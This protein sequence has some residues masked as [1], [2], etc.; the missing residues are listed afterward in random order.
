VLHFQK[1]RPAIGA[2]MTEGELM[3]SLVHEDASVWTG[4][5]SDLQAHPSWKFQL[6]GKASPEGTVQ[7]NS[8]LAKR[9]ALLV[10]AALKSNK[11][12][13]RIVVVKPECASVEP[14]V[15]NCGASNAT[16]PEDRQVKVV[17]APNP[18]GSP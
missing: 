3:K 5:V 4:L 10:D 17:F 16:S 2:A 11:L 12:G 7:Y 8:E 13:D 9:R 14:G 6:V 15:Y 18:G 1:D